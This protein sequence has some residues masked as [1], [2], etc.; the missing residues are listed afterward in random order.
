[1]RGP[2]KPHRIKSPKSGPASPGGLGRLARFARFFSSTEE[3][4]GGFGSTGGALGTHETG[5]QLW[6]LCQQLTRV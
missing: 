2:I 5:F 4:L 1:M 6:R 3:H